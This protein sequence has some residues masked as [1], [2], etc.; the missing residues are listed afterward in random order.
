MIGV[1]DERRTSRSQE[2]DVNSFCEEPG[3]SER[4]VR[5]VT[6]KPVHE[7]SVIQTR[8]SE[9]WKDFNVEQAH[10]RTLRPVI[11]H[12]VIYVSDI[13]QTRSAHESET[14]NVGD[15]TLRERTERSVTDH[16]KSHESTMVNEADMDFLIPG[17]PLSVVK[18]AQSTSV[19]EL[20]QKI[21]NHPDRHDLQ[22]YLRQNQSFNPFSP[23]SKQMIRDVGNI[24]LCELL[25]T[26]PKTQCKACLSYWNIGIVHCTCGHFLHKETEANRK[27]VKYTM[28]LLS[29]PEY[30]IKKG[31]PHGH[32]YGKKPGDKEYYL[33]NQLKKKCQ[34]REFQRIHD[35]FPH[36]QEFR[37]RMIENHRDEELCRRLDALADEDH[38]HHLT[39]QEYFRCKNEWWLHSNKQGSNTITF[40]HRSDF[41]QALSTLQRLQQ[42]AGEE[43][44]VPPYSYKHKRWQSASSSSSTWW[45]WQGPWWS[46]YNSESQE[47]GEP[48][49]E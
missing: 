41:K 1:Q 20:I 11:T 40:K 37:T 4:T 15:E 30:V 18:H 34:K 17:L 10:E 7:T 32:R 42:E 2:I 26:G 9:D 3:S 28:D 31:R 36:D 27:F 47:G 45:N 14:F 33:A 44:H 24:E 23:E 16:D 29:V 19:R 6:G 39:V 22:Q 43:P 46:S 38:T 8:S 48:S 21:E 25:E 49:L 13:S 35:R 12:D 5:P